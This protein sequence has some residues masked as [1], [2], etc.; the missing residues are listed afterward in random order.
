[1]PKKEQRERGKIMGFY[2]V[3]K[4]EMECPNCGA[5]LGSELASFQTKEGDCNLN[6]LDWKKVCNFY[7]LCGVCGTRIE[8]TRKP[9]KDITEFDMVIE[10]TDLP[11]GSM[12]D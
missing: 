1:M 5:Q 8:F 11:N 4:Y 6:T 3:V 9:A 10:V 2:D 7:T 12:Y